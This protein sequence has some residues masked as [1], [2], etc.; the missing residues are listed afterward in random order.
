MSVKA[1]ILVAYAVGV[2]LVGWLAS[3]KK[4]KSPS[5]YFLASRGLGPLIFLATMTAT[6]FSAF[7]VFGASG[8]GYR[9]GFSFFPIIGFGTGFM[10]LTFWFMGRRIRSMGLE[11]H[12][13]TPPD[14]V[15][16]IYR[17]KEVSA[18]FAVVMIVF[19]LP[20]IALQPIA[21]GYAL[22]ELLGLNYMV[23]AILVTG[24]VVIYTF[25]GGMRSVAWTDAFQGLLLIGLLILALIVISGREGGLAAANT[26]I[27]V[28]TP[29][30]FSRPGPG[31][32]FTPALWFSFIFLWF[33]C[34]PMFPQ[35]FQR[36]LAAK[37]EKTIRFTMLAYPFICSLVFILPV[38]IGVLGR[39][40]HPGLHGKAADHIL[41][42]LAAD[43]PG[44]VLGSLVVAC[45]LAALM[46]TLDSQLLTLS[47]IF[48][49]DLYPLMRGRPSR[50]A[51]PGKIFV[52][53]LALAGLGMAA[54]PPSTILS[55]AK[56]TFTGLAV[57]FPVV[58][59]GFNERIRSVKGAWASMLIGETLGGLYY[60][61]LIP[62]FGFLPVVP[63]LTVTFGS[64]LVIAGLE[65]REIPIFPGFLKSPFFY[66]F[67]AIFVAA[68][69]FWRWGSRPVLWLGFPSWLY[70]FLALSALQM[71]VTWLLFKKRPL[72]KIAVEIRISS[73]PGNPGRH[74]PILDKGIPKIPLT[75]TE[76]K[77]Y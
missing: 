7:T 70:Y 34:D 61:K 65:N 57:L 16:K 44:N 37:D 60:F 39:L 72:S 73:F 22:K 15:R 31:G 53:L 55:I 13:I 59:L 58:W 43:L 64:Y 41:P 5:D 69:D 11:T 25:Q 26:K 29:E 67:L 35:L 3:L 74:F 19:T 63:I 38:T 28:R 9:D 24:V 52:V 71:G 40:S 77:L 75:N 12:A 4:S 66:A 51:W 47:S 6:N 76:K 23:G 62:T 46:S 8:A 36:F 42:L 20:Y 45:G 48:T 56:Q 32:H 10:A 30:L 49:E 33:F 14:L 1:G 54:H 68:M 50:G 21:A 17:S 27:L 2:L 18:I